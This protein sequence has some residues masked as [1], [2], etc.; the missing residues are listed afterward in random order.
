MPHTFGQ[1]IGGMTNTGDFYEKLADILGHDIDALQDGHLL[2]E[3]LLWRNKRVD[4][5]PSRPIMCYDDTEGM[6]YDALH[7][8]I[9]LLE[10][11]VEHYRH[12]GVNDDDLTTIQEIMVHASEDLESYE[13][14]EDYTLLISAYEKALICLGRQHVIFDEKTGSVCSETYMVVGPFDKKARASNVVSYMQTKFFHFLVSV[15]KITHHATQGMYSVVPMQDFSKPWT[16]AELYKKYK[17][18]KDEIAFIE[19]MI[20]PM[21]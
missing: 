13:E 1:D 2:F 4:V 3:Q 7:Y 5:T 14:S 10:G 18:T 6:L 20:K 17:L 19:S 15:I 11:L 16:D 9:G 21:E 12:N 8:E